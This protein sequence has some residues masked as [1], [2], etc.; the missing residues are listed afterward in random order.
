MKLMSPKL[1]DSAPADQRP[2]RLFLG[3][4]GVYITLLVVFLVHFFIE[5][6]ERLY[7]VRLVIVD[8]MQ[9]AL[10]A[11]GWK[12]CG[13]STY[14]NYA[15]H[16]AKFE[17][18][19]FFYATTILHVFPF[20]FSD[21][22][23]AL[24][25]TTVEIL[26]FGVIS[27]Y[28]SRILNVRLF[29]VLLT[30][31]CAFLPYW[32]NHY[33]TSSWILY[34]HIP[35]LIFFAALLLLEY[36]ERGPSSRS[37]TRLVLCSALMVFVAICFYEALAVLAFII[38]FA[39]FA[40]Q[41]L[42]VPRSERKTVIRRYIPFLVAF[43]AFASIYI[44]GQRLLPGG[45]DGA[46]M[47]LATMT[48]FRRILYVAAFYAIKSVPAGNYVFQKLYLAYA[49]TDSPYVIGLGR[50]AW[51]NLRPTHYFWGAIVAAVMACY[52]L[53]PFSQHR[54]GSCSIRRIVTVALVS[55]VAG[56]VVNI[57]VAMSLRHQVSL[58]MIYAYAY[59]TFLGF[60]VALAAGLLWLHHWLNGRSK[61]FQLLTI[62]VISLSTGM[63]TALTQ[64]ANDSVIVWQAKYNSRWKLLDSWL[65]T[66]SFKS[67]PLN[68][69]I[70]SRDLLSGD[71]GTV[72]G[73]W[74]EYIRYHAGHMLRVT[75]DSHQYT[76]GPQYVL[77]YRTGRSGPAFLLVTALQSTN[78][79]ED[80]GE[81]A[82]LL[83]VA[84]DDPKQV[85]VTYWT[86]AVGCNCGRDTVQSAAAIVPVTKIVD[87]RKEGSHYTAQAPTQGMIA[88][89]VEIRW[90]EARPSAARMV[91]N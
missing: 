68:A 36:A 71:A 88:G 30:L 58:D 54:P 57:P 33:P 23:R 47:T 87:F 32:G 89:T 60:L 6:S 16:L 40:Q 28:V 50:F 51:E 85:A 78:G 7:Q 73:Y 63:G 5:N 11:A 80:P 35:L 90:P 43:I 91:N 67:L 69:I 46:Q 84:N 66:D 75:S 34:F 26:T 61:V 1:E 14:F 13:F 10:A 2:S 39:L 82:N 64:L 70:V 62:G 19:V 81:R 4:A 9:S 20:L 3:H 79:V 49:G 8:D 53:I 15:E 52:F 55:G 74:P 38:L 77:E 12:C 37:S 76:D 18:R 41:Y 45:Y 59:I 17:A 44:I 65:Q 56:I 25:T 22:V 27:A 83:I 21:T 31:L 42:G 24:T 72:P 48:N 29:P 86:A